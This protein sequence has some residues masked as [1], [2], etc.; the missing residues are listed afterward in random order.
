VRV[1][2]LVVDVWADVA[3]PW[4]WLGHRR[5]ARALE[6]EPAGSVAVRPRAFELRPGVPAEPPASA[7]AGEL[8]Y[9]RVAAEGE[10]S[11]TPLRFDLV[12]PAANTR[13]AHRLVALAHHEGFG[14]RALDA[15]LEGHFAR[16]ADVADPDEAVALVVA[17]VPQLSARGLRAALDAGA[18]ER[19]VAEDEALAA[20]LGVTGVPFFLAGGAVAVSGAQEPATLRELLRAARERLAAA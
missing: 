13:L 19:E 16:G 4:C 14:V 8:G 17:A 5:L 9:A 15:L 1:E 6:D 20:R 12:G 3:C 10:R 18:G 11:G 2:P 7:E